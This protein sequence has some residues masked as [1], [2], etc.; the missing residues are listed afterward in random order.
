M[1]TRPATPPVSSSASTAVLLQQSLADSASS[2]SKKE[3]SAIQAILKKLK[4]LHSPD[5][6]FAAENQM[7]EA[8]YNDLKHKNQH[9]MITMLEGGAYL[10][11]D[12]K[13]MLRLRGLEFKDD[14][15]RM[16]RYGDHEVGGEIKIEKAPSLSLVNAN[17]TILED[18]REKGVTALAAIK[19]C[20]G[21]GAASVNF[22]MLVDKVKE[23]LPEIKAEFEKLEKAGK[24]R[25]YSCFTHHENKFLIGYGMD[26][27]HDLRAL[28]YVGYVPKDGEEEVAVATATSANSLSF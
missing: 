10:A 27:N 4:V 11:V 7:A 19:M 26:F 1:E 6:I 28:P 12:F 24:L 3:E 9:I 22:V 5:E 21:L 2:S 8:V 16:T 23:V 18:L 15:M 17:V 20:L 14:S 25:F 13:R